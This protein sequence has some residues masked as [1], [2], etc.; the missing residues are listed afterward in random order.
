MAKSLLTILATLPSGAVAADL[1]IDGLGQYLR[2]HYHT[3][4]ERDREERHRL[5]D[6]LYRDGGIDAMSK[7]I[8]SVFVDAEI[9]EK[10]KK[11]AR[12]ARFNNVVKRVVN[13]L[14]TVYQEPAVRTVGGEENNARYQVALALCGIHEVAR[15]W[16]R[17]LN[18]HRALL[19]GVRVRQINDGAP[20]PVIDI[21]TPANARLITHPN[22]PSQIVAVA[23]RI[24]PKVSSSVNV[25]A[26]V[27]WSDNERFM[28]NDQWEILSDSFVEHGLGRMPWVFVSLEPPTENGPWPGTAGEDLV[29]AD[30]AIWFTNIALLKETKSATK[31]TIVSGDT[32]TMA[33]GQALDPDI[34]VEAPDGTAINTVD[35]AMDLS[36]FRDTSD[37]IL[38]NVVNNYGMS[39][40]M[41]RHQG[42]QSAEARELMR[43]PL[44]EMRREQQ[45]TLRK[46]ERDVAQ[47]MTVV[48]AADYPD[49]AFQTVEWGINFGEAQTPLS[50][51]EDLER[52]EHE[53]RLGLTDTVEYLMEQDPDLSKEAA[54]AELQRH[55]DVELERNRLMRP[56]QQ[57]SGSMGA[58]QPV[59]EE[60]PSPQP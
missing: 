33:R 45:V 50:P 25:P 35:M 44:R 34:P 53:R 59:G 43:V 58:E 16:N 49:I 52:F 21:V 26:W 36:L 8:D 14:S 48:F 47:V 15:Q 38:E 51:K 40:A 39:S 4:E 29:N 42:V 1:T 22:D 23:I 9:R 18:L 24:K 31:Q 5:R 7:L 2:Q 54:I 20:Q 46:F 12:W 57:V 6:Q 10:R 27:V 28:M 56:L 32:T 30:M 11:W 55:V 17:M 3:Q 60:P 37:H 19:V 13:E 41:A